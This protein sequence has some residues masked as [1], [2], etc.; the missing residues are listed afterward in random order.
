MKVSSNSANSAQSAIAATETGKSSKSS[1]AGSV[2]VASD[3]GIGDSG[4]GD[5]ARVELSARAQDIKRAKELAT[6]SDNTDE[7]KIARLQ[8]LVDSGKY[9]VDAEAVADRLL[10]EH[11]KMI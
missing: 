5:S 7:A 10:D 3:S 2:D 1:K 6:P 9:K 4:I 11:S 8:A